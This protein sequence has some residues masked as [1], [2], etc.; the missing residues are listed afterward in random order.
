MRILQLPVGNSG[1]CPPLHRTTWRFAD[2]LGN[3]AGTCPLCQQ[4][5]QKIESHQCAVLPQLSILVGQTMRPDHFPGMP[6]QKRLWTTA[7]PESVI[8]PPQPGPLPAKVSQIPANPNSIIPCLH[9]C[10]NCHISFLSA[11]ELQQH[12]Q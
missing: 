8:Q 12:V 1:Y 4:L 10:K 9:R 2:L 3:W 11:Q 6:I 5:S 7:F